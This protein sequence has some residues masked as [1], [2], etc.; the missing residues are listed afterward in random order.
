MSSRPLA[1]LP[2]LLAGEAALAELLGVDDAVV[3]VAESARSVVLAAVAELGTSPTVLVATATAREAEQL[4]HDLVPFLGVDA[5]EL[6]PAWETLPF[7]RVSPATETMGRR[8][9]T[10]WRLRHGPA[11]GSAPR[12]GS[13]SRHATGVVVAPIRALLQRLG[14]RVEDAEPVVV[15]RGAEL[16]LADLVAR[17]VHAGYRRE[18]QVEARGE[19][20]VRGGIVDVFGSTASVPTRIDLFGDEVERLTAFE[21]AGQRSVADL[22]QV[23]LFGCREVVLTEDVRERARH[24]SLEAPFARDHF[25]RIADGELFDGMESWLPWLERVRA[26]LH[27]PSRR[28]LPGRAR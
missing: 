28:E 3:A 4:Q 9:R 8:L 2:G 16:D 11:G 14:P 13:G 20:A 18:Y 22:E 27:R 12:P 17:L 25:A 24:L 1:A 5:V 7:E 26:P 19:L 10:M 6:L 21:V 23:E 15:R